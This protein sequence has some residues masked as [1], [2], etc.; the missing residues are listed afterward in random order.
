M[1]LPPIN[2]EDGG[3]TQ[4]QE[5]NGAVSAIPQPTYPSM[6]IPEVITQDFFNRPPSSDS[7]RVENELQQRR[8]EYMASFQPTAQEQKLAQEAMSL[9]DQ[10]TNL[11]QSEEKGAFDIQ[12][13]RIA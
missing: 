13:Q 1:A 8:Q 2:R 6:N 7:Q 10:L 3:Q 11:R 9:E 4:L 5:Q 12:Q